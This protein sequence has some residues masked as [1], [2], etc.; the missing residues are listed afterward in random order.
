MSAAG[1]EIAARA[2]SLVGTRFRPQGRDLALGLDC[3]GAAAAAAGI[4]PER[5]RRDYPLRGQVVGE[6]ENKLGELGWRLVPGDESKAGDVIVCEAGPG[7][8]HLLVSTGTGFVHADAG[9]RRVTERPFPVP[10][11]VLGAWRSADAEEE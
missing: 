11:R 4:P 8:L 7:Q 9:L 3:V 6:I 2:R 1:D 10:W 5:I